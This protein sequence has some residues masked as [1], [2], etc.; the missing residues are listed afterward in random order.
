MYL[1]VRFQSLDPKEGEEGEIPMTAYYLSCHI[2]PV[3]RGPYFSLQHFPPHF[4]KLNNFYLHLLS[5]LFA[6]VSPD[7]FVLKPSQT[8]TTHTNMLSALS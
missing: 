5:L 1:S 2:I 3:I 8:Q 6:L 7:Y 4:W